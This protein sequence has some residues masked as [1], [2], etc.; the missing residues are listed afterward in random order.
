MGE[1]NT[2]LNRK[3]NLKLNNSG[4]EFKV[5][6]NDLSRI[7][8]LLRLNLERDY[9]EQVIEETKDS[10]ITDTE[11]E[12]VG[13]RSIS[14]TEGVLNVNLYSTDYFT[15]RVMKKL[16]E[17]VDSD[18]VRH[19]SYFTP[20]ITLFVSLSIEEFGLNYELIRK[21]EEEISLPVSCYIKKEYLNPSDLSLYTLTLNVL[22]ERLGIPADFYMGKSLNLE[23][24]DLFEYD[25]VNTGIFVRVK[26]KDRLENYENIGLTPVHNSCLK[27]LVHTHH[28][29]QY[30]LYCFKKLLEGM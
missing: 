15:M 12:L 26:I 2:L 16:S 25:T 21:S 5:N 13:L 29:E 23:V 14:Q 27:S 6:G 11:K 17:S 28:V 24:I 10:K 9:I 30:D 19:Y 22:W 3:A 18:H 8:P 4:F 1:I 7:N 20:C